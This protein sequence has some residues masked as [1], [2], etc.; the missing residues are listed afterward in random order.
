MVSILGLLTFMVSGMPA[1][2]SAEASH[3]SQALEPITPASSLHAIAAM[4]GTTGGYS[5]G[6]DSRSVSGYVTLTNSWLDYYTLGYVLLW[7]QRGDA[8]GRY[9]TQQLMTVSA[10]HAF[11][12]R[13]SAAA[14]YAYLKE[15][16]IQYYSDQTEFHFFGAGASYWFSPFALAGFSTSLGL[17]RGRLTAGCHRGFF[18]C[19]VM[20]GIWV[21]SSATVTDA[22]WT[23]TLFSFRETISVPLGNDSYIVGTGEAG[24]RGFY[25]D[26]EALIM[27][28]QRDIQTQSAILK[29]IVHVIDG[30]YLL[31]ALEY[32]GFDSYSVKYGSFGIRVVF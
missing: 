21:T 14:R 13:V 15:G 16:E 10:S 23:P 24:R 8:G 30:L 20:G 31:P 7:L 18:S 28:N 19:D 11:T 17:S 25:F 26:D 5:T 2:D 6:T 3:P 27:Y 32:D 1:L 22:E 29:G 4:Y 12:D 9:Y